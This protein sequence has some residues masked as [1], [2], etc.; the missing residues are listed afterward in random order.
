MFSF[1]KVERKIARQREAITQRNQARKEE[2]QTRNEAIRVKYGNKLGFYL[3]FKI[4]F[5]IYDMF[6][7]KVLSQARI[8]VWKNSLFI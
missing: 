4:D 1:R 6:I 2:R 8:L 5:G 3:T 7:K